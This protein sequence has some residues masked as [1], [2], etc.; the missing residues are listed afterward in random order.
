M[1][2]LSR[3]R[4]LAGLGQI[5]D[6][7]QDSGRLVLIVRRPAVGERALPAEA[8]L[9]QVAG[10]DGDSWLTR[11]S[12]STPDGSA[13]PQRQVTVMNARVAELVAGGTGRMPLAGDQLYLDLDLS[14]GNLPAGSLLAVG[15][16]VLQ[17][18]EAPHLGCAKFV[19]R[20]GVEAMRFVNSRVGRQLR[21]RGMNARVLVSGT[22]RLGDLA[23]KA[24]I[25]L[26]P[27]PR[28]LT[29]VLPGLSVAQGDLVGLGDVVGLDGSESHAQALA[30]LSQ[31]LEG[32]GGGALRGG[33]LRIS[34]VFLDQ[35]GLQRCSD[36]VGRL[37]RVVDGPVPCSVVNHGASIVP[38][39]LRR[40]R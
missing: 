19:E 33:A 37:Q 28:R 10:L 2:H 35:M 26:A 4:L 11:G 8:V 25:R 21:L 13:D 1:E 32:V 22:V 24:P 39:Q 38:L 34:P 3:E 5:R 40:C 36:F 23:V 27:S 6:S 7:P 31:Q 16:A 20:F 18:S 30:S 15:Q 9:D 14:P 29:C 12:T 17:V